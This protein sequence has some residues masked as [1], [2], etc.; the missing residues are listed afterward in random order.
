MLDMLAKD[1]IPFTSYHMPFPSVGY[2]GK[3]SAGGYHYVPASY[4]LSL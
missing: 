1:R 3:D 4:Q 2:V